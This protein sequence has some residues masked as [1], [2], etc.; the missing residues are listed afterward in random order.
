[1]TNRAW[2]E[3][4]EVFGDGHDYD[5]AL[6]SG[7][8][9]S[10]PAPTMKDVFEPSEIAERMMTDADDIIRAIDIPERMQIAQAGIPAKAAVVVDGYEQEVSD[11]LLEPEQL[12]H[13]AIWVSTRISPT[14]TEEYVSPA[15]GGSP[16]LRDAFVGAVFR[17]LQFLCV[18]YYEV[19]FIWVHRRDHFFHHDLT[20][21]DPQDRSKALLSREDLWKIYQLAIKYRA[22]CDRKI[23]LSK[24]WA[25]V[26]DDNPYFDTLYESAQNLEEVADLTDWVTTKYQ[27]RLK[28]LAQNAGADL[29][30][31]DA[32]VDA[33]RNGADGIKYKRATKSSMYEKAKDSLAS[34]FADVSKIV[35]LSS[36]KMRILISIS[37]PV[38]CVFIGYRDPGGS[39]C[40]GLCRWLQAAHM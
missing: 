34:R 31:D 28:E 22:L 32:E 2:D 6:E 26:H 20:A 13:A 27:A 17:V 21:L 11:Y 25:K 14:A 37:A 40:S 5:E 39:A 30:P 38:S 36:I 23:I 7:D 35:I 19:P 18:E 29:I 8:E 12:Q 10:K 33:V 1:M 24:L 4:Q 15:D 3:I 16:R 9:E